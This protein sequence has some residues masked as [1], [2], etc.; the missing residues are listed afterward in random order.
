S[1][2]KLLLLLLVCA[3]VAVLARPSKKE[4][5][6]S[7]E[8]VS[9]EAADGTDSPASKKS[10]ES[11]EDEENSPPTEAL[12]RKAE[13]IKRAKEAKARGLEK[14]RGGDYP[15]PDVWNLA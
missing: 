10:V 15:V 13:G 11:P 4:E 14:A 2:M 8:D 6:I 12:A 7:V 1:N 5:S 9:K 3:A